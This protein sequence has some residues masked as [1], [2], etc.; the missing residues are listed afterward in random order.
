MRPSPLG[1][2]QT[3]CIAVEFPGHVVNPSRALE[4]LGGQQKLNEG[5]QKEGRFIELRYRSPD[6]TPYRCCRYIVLT[7]QYLRG[8]SDYIESAAARQCF[9]VLHRYLRMTQ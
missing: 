1:A 3:K 5:F 6:A 2:T 4:M 9:K 8:S 7:S